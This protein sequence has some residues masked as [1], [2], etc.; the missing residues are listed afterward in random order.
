MGKKKTR[1]K[2]VPQINGTTVQE[3]VIHGGFQEQNAAPEV[4]KITKKKPPLEKIDFG[5]TFGEPY[6]KK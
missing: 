3:K 1:I 5:G 4:K 2:M 6:R